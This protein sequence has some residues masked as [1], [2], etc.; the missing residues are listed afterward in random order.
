VVVIG[1]IV[2]RSVEVDVLPLGIADRLALIDASIDVSD[3]PAMRS[4]VCFAAV[5]LLWEQSERAEAS[6]PLASRSVPPPRWKRWAECDG[7][8]YSYGVGV[9]EALASEDVM[10]LRKYGDTVL[11]DAWRSLNPSPKAVEE[12]AKNSA[13]GVADSTTSSGS[14]PATSDLPLPSST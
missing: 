8:I 14:A 1:P 5:G 7:D 12:A 9:L 6:V 3:K 4:R 11:T 13:P 10:A 2:L